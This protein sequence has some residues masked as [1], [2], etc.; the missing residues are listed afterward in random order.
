MREE[1]DKYIIK[2]NSDGSTLITIKDIDGI[3]HHCNLFYNREKNFKQKLNIFKTKMT[4]STMISSLLT[5]IVLSCV[6]VLV[7]RR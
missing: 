7:D 1:N 4:C 5:A 2:E 6:S 3:E